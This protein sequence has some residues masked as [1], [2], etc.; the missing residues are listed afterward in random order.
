MIKPQEPDSILKNETGSIDTKF[1]L[2][3]QNF[4]PYTILLRLKE[5]NEFIDI[6]EVRIEKD[7]RSIKERIESRSFHDVSDLYKETK[8]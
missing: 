2:L 3:E 1:K 5:N 4:G 7:F 8:E 6:V